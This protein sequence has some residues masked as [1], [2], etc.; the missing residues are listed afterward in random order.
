[1]EAIL[2]PAFLPADFL[3]AESSRK[4]ILKIQKVFHMLTK[5]YDFRVLISSKLERGHWDVC[6]IIPQSFIITFPYSL[7]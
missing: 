1:M 4:I 2:P 6:Y 5:K 7:A 3:A